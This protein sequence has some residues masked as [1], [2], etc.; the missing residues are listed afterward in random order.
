MTR[1]QQPPRHASASQGYQQGQAAPLSEDDSELSSVPTIHEISSDS[2]P[3]AAQQQPRPRPQTTMD[4][5]QGENVGETQVLPLETLT[6]E[7][8]LDQ[9]IE[10]LVAERRIE[11]KRQRLEALRKGEP[12]PLSDRRPQRTSSSS[13]PSKRSKNEGSNLRVPHQ[14][15][16]GEDFAELNNYLTVLKAR[17][18]LS[19]HE[20]PDD[21]AKILYASTTFADA[22][23]RRWVSYVQHT[24]H[25]NFE[26]LT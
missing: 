21:K 14:K 26:G 22:A 4:H 16:R 7:Q 11:A 2:A 5:R 6:E 17:F 3:A 25:G 19:P 12:D 10:R 20:F 18:A 23:Q 24:L 13:P 8:A 1:R 15:F 9:E